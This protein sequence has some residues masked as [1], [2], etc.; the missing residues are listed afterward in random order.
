MRIKERKYKKFVEFVLKQIH[1][2]RIPEFLSKYSKRMYSIWQHLVLLTLR[3]KLNLSY[4]EFADWLEESRVMDILQLTITPHYTTL[5][6][7][8]KR[9]KTFWLEA[10]ISQAISLAENHPLI[11]C[12]DATGFGVRHGSAYYC[13]RTLI[14]RKRRRWVKLSI[15]GD[16]KTQ[17]IVSSV[18]KMTPRH[19]NED[20]IPVLKKISSKKIIYVCADKAYDSEKIRKFIHDKLDTDCQIPIKRC[21]GRHAGFYR[22]RSRLNLD[23]Y[24]KRSLAETIFSVIKRMFGSVLRAKYFDMRAKEILFKI[25]AYN[26]IRLLKIT[27]FLEDFY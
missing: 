11:I 1:K 6:K 21:L 12:V 27:L 22:K 15:A 26:T 8:S 19:D 16:A 7:F 18:I 23:K 9:A 13:D 5:H 25:I 14:V 3:Q 4:R 24:H 2:A 10:I 20:I 17:L